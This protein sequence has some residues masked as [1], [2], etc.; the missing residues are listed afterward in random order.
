[1][2]SRIVGD[3]HAAEAAAARRRQ[4]A[5]ER[6]RQEAAQ[7]AQ[8][9]AEQAR[10]AQQKTHNTNNAFAERNGIDS[11]FTR[12]H[13]Q[14]R[15]ADSNLVGSGSI[16]VP[17]EKSGFGKFIDGAAD[18]LADAGNK[19]GDLASDGYELAS[20]GVK[21]YKTYKEAELDGIGDAI[22]GT[23]D[24]IVHPRET[25]SNLIEAGLHPRETVNQIKD[26]LTAMGE[27]FAAASPERKAEMAGN[28]AGQIQVELLLGKG[29]GALGKR[30]AS[31]AKTTSAARAANKFDAAIEA[32]LKSGNKGKILEG[33]IALSVK[34]DLVNFNK[35]F[36]P[37]GSLG[38]IDVET[39][40]AIIEATTGKGSKLKQ[41]SEL[42][43]DP[44]RN[45]TGKPVILYTTHE[46]F[47]K[48]AERD[49]IKAGGY[50]VRNDAELHALLEVLKEK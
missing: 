11:A 27:E 21:L 31:I 40:T 12:Q 15:F 22:K 4:E 14:F 24:L 36:G 8:R 2:A 42:I 35:K 45:P 5:A 50:V 9:E 33:Q 49:I 7:R 6:A 13:F 18:T 16:D 30:G 38:E 26:S 25:I 20:D 48:A 23:V 37:N 41:V 19:V 28:L 17:E 34:Q 32:A 10:L 44:V 1:M 39:S 3:N 46:K 47:T 43:S 29:A